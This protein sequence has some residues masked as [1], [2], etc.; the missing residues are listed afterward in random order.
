MLAQCHP[1]LYADDSALLVSR[2]NQTTLESILSVELTNI[3]KL[4]PHLGKTEGILFGS[5]MKLSESSDVRVQLAGQVLTARTA[6]NYLG[7]TLD[8]NLAGREYG[9]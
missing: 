8:G 2:I 7:C 5:K 4:S 3:N 9:Y 1:F 6:V